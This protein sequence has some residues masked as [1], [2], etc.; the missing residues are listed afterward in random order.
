MICKWYGCLRITCKFSS[1]LRVFFGSRFNHS[2][3]K[4]RYAPASGTLSMTIIHRCRPCGSERIRKNGHANNGAQRAKCLACGRT[5]HLEPKGPRY[6]QKFKTQVLSA[7]E[8]R[9]STRGIRRTFGVCY[10]TLM[11]EPLNKRCIRVEKGKILRIDQ[12]W[13][14]SDKLAVCSSLARLAA[15][16]FSEGSTRWFAAWEW[17][18]CL[19]FTA[20]SLAAD[21]LWQ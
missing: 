5:F 11:K 7:Y 17:L 15:D 6:D 14:G 19:F 3:L 21:T 16:W 4:R 1:Y 13:C 12:W 9:M 18:V 20:P 10:P 2:C 8:D